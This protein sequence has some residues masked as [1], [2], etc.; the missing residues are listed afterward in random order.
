[1]DITINNEVQESFVI[2]GALRDYL[3]S[4][5]R[6]HHVFLTGRGASAIH[7]IL[8][9]VCGPGSRV[10]IPSIICPSV[11]QAIIASGCQPVY[12]DIRLE[13]FNLDPG[14]MDILPGDV[15]AVI[16]PHMFG[17]PLRIEEI[18]RKCSE[19]NILLIEDIAQSAGVKYRNKLLGCFGDV[20]IMSFHQSKISG[21][22][23]GGALIINR[24]AAHLAEK[25]H[26]TIEELPT[27]PVDFQIRS[28][29]I[30]A[31]VNSLLEG[32]RNGLGGENEIRRIYLD[33][34]DLIPQREKPENEPGNLESFISLEKEIVKRK[35]RSLKYRDLIKFPY[36]RHPELDDGE[37]VFRYSII[38]DGN[39]GPDLAKQLTNQLRA[40]GIHASNLYYPAHRIFPDG[41]GRALPKSSWVSDRIIN[42]WL[43]DCATDSYIQKTAEIIFRI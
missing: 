41:S 24:S 36:V 3:K 9:A 17:H 23:G 37:P 26:K 11:P 42:L 32:A 43:D 13:D 7:T 19:R 28:R 12:L 38:I 33:N 15:S 35:T 40:S 6:A 5:F 27:V 2:N 18:K 29:G 20:A 31:R 10:A 22:L 16:A 34:L 14:E 21:G 25:I 4:A 30:S 1:M 39:G 8:K